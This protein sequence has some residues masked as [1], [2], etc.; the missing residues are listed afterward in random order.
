MPLLRRSWT[1]RPGRRAAVR[2]T[3]GL[4]SSRRR[5]RMTRSPGS[6]VQPRLVAAA[7]LRAVHFYSK[8][9]AITASANAP[10][11]LLNAPARGQSITNRTGNRIKMM[12]LIIN[13]GFVMNT[14]GVNASGTVDITKRWQ[15][16]QQCSLL[17]F[18]VP[19]PVVAAPPLTN[20]YAPF[21]G[22]GHVDTWSLRRISEIPS[23]RLL[24][25]VNISMK[26]DL[27]GPGTSV[28]QPVRCVPPAKPFSLKINLDQLTS[29]DNETSSFDGGINGGALY[30][31]LLGDYIGDSGGTNPS[32]SQLISFK[33]EARLAFTNVD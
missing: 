19:A 17:L 18:Y 10:G 31:Y 7:P 2:S 29:F 1:R 24:K 27:A 3:Y 5:F 6:L 12:S 26:T 15:F 8:G 4:R 21:E 28:T 33:M 14:F 11:L 22:V 25:R 16:E 20:Y 13:G 32:V 9:Q 30:L 23:M